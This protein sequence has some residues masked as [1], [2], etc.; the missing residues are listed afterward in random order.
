MIEIE[1]KFLIKSD[2]YK[3]EC[4]A[5]I[6][7][8]QGFLSTDPLRT[9]RI[10][11]KGDK[12]FITVKGKSNISGTSRFEWEREIPK[13]E[14]EQLLKL[15]LPG[16]IDKIRYEVKTGN[17]VFEVDEFLGE[18]KGLVIA[19]IE[20]SSEEEDFPRPDWLGEEVTGQTK[21]YNSQLSK[22]PFGKW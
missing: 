12:G 16:M 20:L 7:I 2:A 17:F 6:R 11:L 1:R 15:C 22:L 5:G 13:N 18:N 3:K 9:V 19:E 4:P 10:R 14:A 21:Y 8:Q